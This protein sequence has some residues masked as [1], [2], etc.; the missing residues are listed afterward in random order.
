MREM[1]EKYKI[2]IT[3]DKTMPMSDFC[4]SLDV[5]PKRLHIHHTKSCPNGY[6][7]FFTIELDNAAIEKGTLQWT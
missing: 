6:V 7:H 2:K 4:K 1:R 3:Q 5:D